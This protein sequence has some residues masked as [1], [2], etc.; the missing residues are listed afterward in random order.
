[1][2]SFDIVCELDEHELSNAV[3]QA[4]REVGTRFDFKGSNAKFDLNKDKIKLSAEADFQLNQMLDVL[5]NKLTK[6]SI[7]LGHMEIGDPVIQHKSAE[8]IVTMKQGI[9]TDIAKKVVK[10]LKEKKFKVQ[11][12]IQGD[13]VLITF[14]KY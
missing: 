1:M 9:P 14:K 12:S 3:D 8:Q 6:R 10:L 5:K 13:Q 7:D 4:N 2:P 11:A